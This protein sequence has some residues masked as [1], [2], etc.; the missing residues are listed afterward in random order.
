M[1][2]LTPMTES[3][4]SAHPMTVDCGKI[5]REKIRLE[6]VKCAVPVAMRAATNRR[7]I[8]ATI[9]RSNQN[10]CHRFPD[11]PRISRFTLNAE[12]AHTSRYITQHPIMRS[13]EHTSEL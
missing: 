3:A 12:T 2:K 8:A 9:R 10:C 11:P 7:R 5:T 1:A 6:F 4:A 13:E